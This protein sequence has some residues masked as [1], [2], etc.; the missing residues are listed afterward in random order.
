MADI[1]LKHA[2]D[3]FIKELLGQMWYTYWEDIA[4]AFKAHGPNCDEEDIREA[5]DR[6]IEEGFLQ[7]YNGY[8]ALGVLSRRDLR[9][10]C[11]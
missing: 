2:I 9:R 3:S 8:Y 10:W 1:Y 4:D 5:L 11:E 7:H 6:L